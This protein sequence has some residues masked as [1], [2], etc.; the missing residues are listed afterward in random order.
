MSRITDPEALAHLE[1]RMVDTF[2]VGYREY[3]GGIATHPVPRALF[4][5]AIRLTDTS[6]IVDLLNRWDSERRKSNPGKKPLIPLRALVVLY[7]LN[8]QMGVGVTYGELA[9]TLTYRS[10]Q[11]TSPR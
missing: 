11:N 8:T 5:A 4:S 7:L 2:G 6:G 10:N 1:K 3:D 9:R